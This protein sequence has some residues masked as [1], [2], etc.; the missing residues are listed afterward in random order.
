M[1]KVKIN[2]IKIKAKIG[3]SASERKKEQLLIVSLNYNYT[4]PAQTNI[5]NIEFLKDYSKIIKYLK[6]FIKKSHYRTLEKLVS[7]CRKQLK[8]EF[9]LKN[10]FLSIEKPFVAKKYGCQSISVSQ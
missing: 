2:N 7:E 3:V 4:L 1:F 8:K 9:K 10:V 5:N 6:N